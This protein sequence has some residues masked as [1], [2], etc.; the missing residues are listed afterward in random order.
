MEC[1]VMV[2][3]L[4]LMMLAILIFWQTE[5][6]SKFPEWIHRKNTQIILILYTIV[7]IV[8]IIVFVSIMANS[9]GGSFLKYALAALGLHF[10]ALPLAM[11]LLQNIISLV[12]AIVA[13]AL[14]CLIIY[15]AIQFL[16]IS[17]GIRIQIITTFRTIREWAEI[18]FIKGMDKRGTILS[19][20]ILWRQGEFVLLK[21]Q[22]VE[23]INFTGEIRGEKYELK[24]FYG[25]SNM[26]IEKYTVMGV[27]LNWISRAMSWLVSRSTA[28]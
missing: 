21:K 13:L 15:I 18:I 12:V 27:A 8:V 20:R 14:L 3:D 24:R 4:C 16:L 19:W 10:I 1:V 22:N 25:R 7:T 11:L 17:G 2:I 26:R 6:L 5:W 28:M 23:H 9:V